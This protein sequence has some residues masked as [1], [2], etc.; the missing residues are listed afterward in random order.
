VTSDTATVTSAKAAIDSGTVGGVNQGLN[1]VLTTGVDTIIGSNGND[2]ITADQTGTNPQLTAADTINGGAGTDT[3]RYFAKAADST[4]TTG[5]LSGVEQ[6]YINSGTIGSVATQDLSGLTGVTSIE[7]DAQANAVDY[8]L[9]ATQSIKFSNN[10]AATIYNDTVKYGATVTTGNIGLNAVGKAGV[11]AATLDVRGN[12]LTTLNLTTSGANSLVT[13]TNGGTAAL[14]TIN[15]SG[16]KNLSLTESLN[17]VKTINASTMTGNLSANVSGATLDAAFAFTGGAGNDNITVAAGALALISA[18]G[19][20][21]G[22]AGTDTLTTSETASLTAAQVA[23]VNAAKNFEVLGFAASGSGVDVSALTSINQFKVN[24]GNFSETFTNANSNSKFTIDNSAG[25]SGT[26]AIS[27]KVGD[28]AT[29]ITIDNT[30]ATAAKT[31]ATLTLS[32]ITNVALT[33]SGA[34]QNVITA[35]NNAENSAIT[36]TGSADLSFTLK[37]PTA[38]SGIGSKVDGSAATGKLTLTANTQT[39][40]AGSSL[41]DILIG[42]SNA[43]TLKAGTNSGSLTGN[44]GNDT[45]D[46][47]AAVTGATSSFNTTTVTDFSK[48]DVLKVAAKGTEAFTATAVNVSAASTL[49]AAIDLA[50]AGDGSTNGIIRW[51]QFGGNTYVVEDVSAGT[52]IQAADIVVKLTGTLDLSTSTFSAAAHTLTFA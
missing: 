33:S 2:T 36:V 50:S 17:L 46:V 13:L 27:N 10:N 9:A 19:Q 25:N 45:F 5:T 37:N 4:L 38:S 16:D 12:A 23:K 8:T 18:G 3:L 1:L 31:L 21:D 15:V 47:S 6:L 32:G 35:F 20:L 26:V 49:A 39:F 40:A 51:F 30:G 52:T 24:A 44:A 48:G 11:G 28:T 41:G 29:A 7:Q 22:G 34:Q 42:G 43:D 14:T